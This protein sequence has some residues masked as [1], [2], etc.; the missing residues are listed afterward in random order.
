MKE[1]LPESV[2]M[3]DVEI[4]FQDEA[5]VGQK[6]TTTRLW[7]IKGT[8]PRAIRQEQYEYAYIFGAVCPA[9][10]L[11]VGL[12]L[13][14]VNSHAMKIHLEHISAQIEKGKHAVIVLDRAAWH[15]TNK[16]KSFKNITLLFLPPA[17][18]ELNPTEQLWQ[19]LRDR[20]LANRS[21]ENY[22]D[23]VQ[24]SCLAWNHYVDMP[25]AIRKLCSRT[26][27]NLKN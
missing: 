24:S 16:I 19:Q 2:K 13:P 7:A 18:P 9:R 12:V 3:D 11:A 10:D 6:G 21:F 20:E 27:A 8:R 1:S 25:G 15:T 4:W 17:S 26:W 23:I 14:T 5:R 22:D